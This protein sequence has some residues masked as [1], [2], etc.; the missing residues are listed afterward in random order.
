MKHST[1]ERAVFDSGL[2]CTRYG[3]RKCIA[4]GKWYRRKAWRSGKRPSH[5]RNGRK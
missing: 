4:R 1:E 5:H 2:H 3:C